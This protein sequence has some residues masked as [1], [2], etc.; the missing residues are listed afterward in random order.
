MTHRR[1]P[2]LRYF[3]PRPHPAR[4]LICFPHAGGAAGFYRPWSDL[5]PTDTDLLAVQYPGR[6][7]RLTE[8]CIPTMDAL[9]DQI[10]HALH[11]ELTTPVTFFGHSMGAS[12]AYEVARRLPEGNVTHLVVSAR[13]APSHQ[14]KHRTDVHTQD[15]ESLLA[16]VDLLG[17]ADTALLAHPVLRSFAL[18][19]IRNDF[20]LIETY[21]PQP[22]TPLTIPITSLSADN[23]PRMTVEEANWSEATT[24]RYRSQV[25]PGGH[26]YLTDHRQAVIDEILFTDKD[27]HMP[28]HEDLTV[29]GIRTSVATLLGIPADNITPDANLLELGVDSMKLMMLAS[30]WQQHGAEVPFA[31]LAENPTPN[32]W[33]KLLTTAT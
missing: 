33:S 24:T 4:T 27:S 17:G 16:E 6:G 18:P 1:G 19:V 12:V 30:R 14:R 5:L 9:A 26:F 7:D 31:D 2:W 22:A 28:I 15:D 29:D 23:D 3:H 8:P 20:R 11:Q 25:F 10:A 21:R 32:H 13:P